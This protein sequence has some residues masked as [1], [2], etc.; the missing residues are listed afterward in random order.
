MLEGMVRHALMNMEFVKVKN[1][2][3]LVEVNATAAREHVAVTEPNIHQVK[4]R[5]RA[6]TSE[7]PFQWIPVI[8]LVHAVYFCVF[9][10]NASLNWPKNYGFFPCKIVT[11]LTTDYIRSCK[12]GPGSYVEAS[13][14]AT[15]TNNNLER[16]KNCVAFGPAGSRHGLV[17]CFDIGTDKILYRRTV[18]QIPWPRDHHLIQKVETWDKQGMCAIK[19]GC[20]RFLNRK[21]DK[22]V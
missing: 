12:V 8:I 18:T 16:T 14:N 6:T 7:Y 11:G 10:L 2:V 15:V 13:A 5:V 1:L 17:K 21:G 22:F 19:Q 4:E 9:W 20:I 3:S